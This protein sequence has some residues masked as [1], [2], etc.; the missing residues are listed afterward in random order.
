[1]TAPI[2]SLSLAV[3]DR[4][5]AC[6]CLVG[7][8]PRPQAIVTSG[9]KASDLPQGRTPALGHRRQHTGSVTSTVEM[10]D[11]RPAPPEASVD[12]E[13]RERIVLGLLAAPGVTHDLA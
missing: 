13:P 10:G 9:M 3:H 1:M 8:T 6:S 4:Q 12:R 11:A 5:C 7:I 2:H